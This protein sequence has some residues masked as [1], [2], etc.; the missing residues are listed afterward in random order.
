MSEF[1]A[2]TGSI[3]GTVENWETVWTLHARRATFRKARSD[4]FTAAHETD[5]YLIAE[6]EGNRL[7]NVT[8]AY[9]RGLDW[10]A[11]DYTE[12]AEYVGLKCEVAS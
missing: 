12:L 4:G 2:V 10:P 5:D 1:A 3:V 6:V 11:D 9:G 8:D 7:V